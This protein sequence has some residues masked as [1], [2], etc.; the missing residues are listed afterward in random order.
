VRAVLPERRRVPGRGGHATRSGCVVALQP[1]RRSLG[2]G[3]ERAVHSRTR[4]DVD[5]AVDHPKGTMA[6]PERPPSVAAWRRRS[7][8]RPK[9]RVTRRSRGTSARA[10]GGCAT[11]TATGS[12]SFWSSRRSRSLP[13]HRRHRGVAVCSCCSR[14][15]RS[16]WRSGHPASREPTRRSTTPLSRLRPWSQQ[17]TSSG[18]ATH[19]PPRAGF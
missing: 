4:R 17:P 2:S 12:F 7:H 11:A 14:D 3:V 8:T 19:W 10:S 16:S 6:L 15:P 18:P 5:Q 1:V 13:Q 9:P